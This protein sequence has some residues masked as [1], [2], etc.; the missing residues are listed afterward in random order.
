MAQSGAVLA[1]LADWGAAQGIGFSHLLSM[2]DMADVDFGDALDIL[3]RDLE[4]HAI[5]MYVEGITQGRKFMSAARGVARMKPVIVLKAGRHAA[6]AAAA[7]SHTGAMAGRTAVYDAAFARAGLVQVAGLGELFD[8]AETLGHAG[9]VPRNE[10]LAIVS[11]GGGLGIA[12]ADLL[13]D[14]NGELASLSAETMERLDKLMPL[15]WSR[16]NPVDIAGDAD[17][18]RYASAIDAL[19]ADRGVGAVL[20]M[21][22]PT[23]LTSAEGRRALIAAAPGAQQG[24]R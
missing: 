24:C 6:T 14:G 12:T 7:A 15:I 22:V 19:A 13:M 23:A 4:T 10:R 18:A 3:S 5:L 11:N 1:A 17:G 16:A 21:N 9:I 8:A 2:G 20:A